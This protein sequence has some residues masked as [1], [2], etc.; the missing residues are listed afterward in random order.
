MKKKL[1]IS[2]LVMSFSL[3]VA[4]T[5]F[6]LVNNKKS[7]KINKFDTNTNTYSQNRQNN[8]VAST[9]TKGDS[10][11]PTSSAP[12]STITA[13]SQIKPTLSISALKAPSNV[14][15]DFICYGR[16][17][18]Y[19][20]VILTNTASGEKVTTNKVQIKSDGKSSEAADIIWKTREGK[21]SVVASVSADNDQVI[22]SDPSTIEVYQ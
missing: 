22:Y 19:C 5:V 10:T 4:A 9:E 15:I 11:K 16:Q 7:T 2:A 3:L 18:D 13:K 12:T 6:V 8:G 20:Y 21:W 17:G 1:A 14:D